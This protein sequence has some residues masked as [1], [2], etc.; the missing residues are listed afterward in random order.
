MFKDIPE[1]AFV[2]VHSAKF[3][4]EEA[5]F[6]LRQAVRRYDV[7]HVCCNDCHFDVWNSLKL[8]NWPT[9][10]LIGPDQNVIQKL[11]EEGN[12]EAV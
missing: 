4:N 11:T 12:V 7:K 8:I 1:V 2:G 10:M 9:L 3:D 5:L 6:M